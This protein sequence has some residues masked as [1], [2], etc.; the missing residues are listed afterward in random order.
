MDA[1]STE[2]RSVL[3]RFLDAPSRQV[4]VA[5]LAI[6][7]AILA[8]F[9][10]GQ[11]Q[12]YRH[13]TEHAERS[14][15]NVAHLLAEHAARTFD[16]VDETL[17]AVGRLRGD[18]ARGIYRSRDSIFVHLK[19][20]HGGSPVLA[21][22]GWFDANGERVATSQ[23]IDPPSSSVA[24]QE[25]FRVHRDRPITG[26]HVSVPAR[27][28]DGGWRIY[29][30]RRI[31]NLDGSFA[32]VVA[33]TVDP[34]EFAS[35]YRALEL[36]PGHSVTL[37]RRD[38][39]VLAR[40]PDGGLIGRELSDDPVFRIHMP[41][42]GSGTYHANGDAGAGRIGSYALVPRMA[43]RLLVDVAVSR[44]HAL[45]EF[46]QALVTD[47]VET[48]FGVA[49]LLV[50]ARLLM[51]QLRRRE[52]LQV[53]LAEATATATA[54]RAE[55]ES[56]NRAKSD[57]LA[58][59]SHELRTPL[60]A[61][62]GFAQMLEI[63][64]AHKLSERQ[65]EYVGYIQRGGEHLLKLVNEV[66]DLAGVEAGRL[67]MSIE[68]IVVAEA[69]TGV[70]E[71][72][73]PI[74]AKAGITLHVASAL[75]LPDL[76]ADGLRLR[77]VLI[78][79]IANGIKYNRPN[80][81][82]IVATSVHAGRVR[83]TVTDT[84]PGIPR[85]RHADLFE[86]FHRLGAEY[87]AVEG[88]GL[89]LALAKRLVAA[90]DGTIGFTSESGQGS[91]FWIELPVETAVATP[92]LSA[93]SA[94]ACAGRAAT[95]SY[96][97]LYVEDNPANLRLMEHLLSTLP[98]VVM[99][100]APTP[101][102]GLDLALAHRPDVIVLDINLPGMSG[103]DVL[104]RLKAMPETRDIPVLA[105]TAAALPGDV[106]RGQA[107]GFLRYLTKPIDVKALIEALDAALAMRRPQ[108]EVAAA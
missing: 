102:L 70:E 69:L 4:A 45:D 52:R 47:A 24:D 50:G 25:F 83:F 14:T 94:A 33:G 65:K 31:E 51:L 87:T 84:G 104:A 72:M 107:A 39:I 53:E 62:I 85:E 12:A 9:A 100:S 28:A 81:D 108:A 46:R 42:A 97:V 43:E 55:A 13:A 78:N 36:G 38:G 91:S 92:A 3:A 21:E 67:S 22:V 48:G 88:S 26:V 73:Q 101:E 56:A 37:L 34:A 89:G 68:R 80:G 96:S 61:V 57:F 16:G 5:A 90:M 86:P 7:A 19:T 10:H 98:S 93:P 103:Y 82:V 27:L 60:N 35:A 30:S 20:L 23:Q 74:A 32:G 64:P 79:L 54:A 77:Q 2:Q 29:F 99:L 6:C 63:D 17:R 40:S 8:A 75:E 44:A 59:M 66:L 41:Q 106:R 11:W 105:L 58:R 15:R 1:R 49:V 95:G 76:R 71:I 18:V